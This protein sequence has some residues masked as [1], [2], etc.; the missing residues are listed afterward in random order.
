M[1]AQEKLRD[2]MWDQTEEGVGAL[3]NTVMN[4]EGEKLAGFVNREADVMESV[5]NF[6]EQIEKVK[7]DFGFQFNS[8]D[9][10]LAH[11]TDTFLM[12]QVLPVKKGVKVND[13]LKPT[14]LVPPYMLGVHIL[15]FLP[16]ENKSY[17]HSFANEG[18]PT[19]V[20]VV[21]DILT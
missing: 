4:L 6:N 11:E 19:Y 10:K 14:L 20:R 18:I 15:S 2:F 21:K 8:P 17:A 7:D 12:Y 13:A 5:A 9:Y 16:Y 1:G 3:M